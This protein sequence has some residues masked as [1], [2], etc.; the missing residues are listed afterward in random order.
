MGLV[1]FDNKP[2]GSIIYASPL[3]S[4]LSLILPFTV[5]NQRRMINYVC[6]IFCQRLD[7]VEEN[8]KRERSKIRK[9]IEHGEEEMKKV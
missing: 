7:D 4:L 8:A 6:V 9:D 3:F 5:C 1:T 2:S